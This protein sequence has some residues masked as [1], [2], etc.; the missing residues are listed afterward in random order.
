MP[1][2]NGDTQQNPPPGD[3]DARLQFLLQSSESL[4]ANLQELHAQI[5]ERNKETDTRFDKILSATENLLA[6]VRSHQD[7]LDKLEGDKL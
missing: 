1:I 5:A 6:I 3:F 2:G 7:R 4:H